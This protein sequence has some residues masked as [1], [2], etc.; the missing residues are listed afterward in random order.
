MKTTAFIAKITRPKLSGVAPQER[1]FD[2]LDQFK[3]Y[4]LL[5][6]TAPGGSG[7]TTLAA[8]YLDARKLSSLW[9]QLDQGDGDLAGFFHYLG[10]AAK[11]TAPRYKK[12][13]PHLTP[14]YLRGV[15]VFARRYFETLFQ[16]L[17][18]NSALVFDNYQDI[19]DGSGFPEILSH[20]LE[21]VPCGIRI[22][23][24]SRIGP[25]PALARLRANRY[26]MEL[27][28]DDIRFTPDESAELL[29]QHGHSLPDDSILSELHQRTSGWAAGLVLLTAQNNQ[30]SII[31]ETLSNHEVFAYFASEIFDRSSDEIRDLLLRTTF[32]DMI[33]PAIAERLTGNSAAGTILEKLHRNHFFTQRY[34]RGYRYHPLFREFLRDRARQQFSPE[35]LSDMQRQAAALFEESGAYVTAAELYLQAGDWENLGRVAVVHAPILAGHG[36][37]QTLTSWLSSIP[38]EIKES[39]PWVGY[40]LGASQLPYSPAAA[41]TL[42]EKAYQGFQTDGDMVG[43]L[44]SCSSA[45]DSIAHNWDDYRP[46]D[47]WITRLEESLP[48]AQGALPPDMAARMALSL[49][50]GMAIR[51]PYREDVAAGM[52]RS[53]AL[54]RASSD[55]NL[56]FQGLLLAQNYYGWMGDIPTCSPHCG[57]IRRPC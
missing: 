10:L 55:L 22:L 17:P 45:I 5:W 31:P 50:T 14:E 13:L 20:A 7:K 35:Q 2:L 4:P 36:R 37:W 46:M 43:M 24:L 23:I 9:Y 42:M 18:T 32:L 1:L 51:Q 34:E 27:G 54:T 44:I 48:L 3:S 15:P 30:T 21:A 19:P 25:P 26:L 47:A 49:A 29:M 12:P 28:W 11:K 38:T 57:S 56:Q 16:R 52:E 53:L 41:R 33:A 40:W 8:S 39:A 6:I